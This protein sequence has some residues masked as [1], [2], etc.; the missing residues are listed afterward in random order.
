[1]SYYKTP[2]DILKELEKL[3]IP[4]H[5]KKSP[6]N[7]NKISKLLKKKEALIWIHRL[8]CKKRSGKKARG[9]RAGTKKG[10]ERAARPSAA[11]FRPTSAA[12]PAAGRAG[13][14][15]DGP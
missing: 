14:T 6:Q 3:G 7:K 13:S 4:E 1:M 5:K 2:R 12:F 9:V 8:H 15:R 10:S 11:T